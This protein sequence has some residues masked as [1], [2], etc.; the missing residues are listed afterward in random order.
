[1]SPALNSWIACTNCGGAG[2][3]HAELRSADASRSSA[4]ASLGC[5]ERGS[6]IVAIVSR[7]Q[8]YTWPT[9]RNG[10]RRT[11]TFA[12]VQELVQGSRQA[13]ELNGGVKVK[14][15]T[16]LRGDVIDRLVHTAVFGQGDV[17]DS[18]R[19]LIW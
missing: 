8:G 15:P 19:W 10:G 5:V 13:I 14:D 16:A 18:A 6:R 2:S 3:A 11:M 1:N 17:R 9:D 4:R 7:P 12:S